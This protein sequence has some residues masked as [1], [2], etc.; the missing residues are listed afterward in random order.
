ML[1]LLLLC[2]YFCYYLLLS[3]L[4]LLYYYLSLLCY[5]LLL[6]CYYLLLLLLLFVIIIVVI[7][8]YFVIWQEEEIHFCLC[9][10][11]CRTIEYPIHYPLGVT[12]HQALSVRTFGN[13]IR[14]IDHSNILFILKP[15]IVIIINHL[16]IN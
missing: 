5:Y 1:Y 9:V 8:Y 14:T 15:W 4:L 10:Y 3:I 13:R 7:C 2:H 6:L 12:N 11:R 16:M